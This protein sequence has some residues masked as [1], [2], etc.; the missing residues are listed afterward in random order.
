MKA[1]GAEESVL[2]SIGEGPGGIVR[3]GERIGQGVMAD[4]GGEGAGRRRGSGAST[5]A[6]VN[7]FDPWRRNARCS[8]LREKVV[9]RLSGRTQE[10]PLEASE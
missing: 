8:K 10:P 2:A 5:W 1:G 6:D 9:A 4:L 7:E 3:S